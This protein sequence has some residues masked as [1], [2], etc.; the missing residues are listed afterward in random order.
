MAYVNAGRRSCTGRTPSEYRNPIRRL[1][2]TYHSPIT[3]VAINVWY[4]ITTDVHHTLQKEVNEVRISASG[5]RIG[6]V[7]IF[8]A[9]GALAFQSIPGTDAKTAMKQSSTGAPAYPVNGDGQTY[10]F[11]GDPASAETAP[12][13]I[14][15]GN[16]DGTA[17]YVLKTDVLGE[18]PKTSDDGSVPVYA[19]DG[20]TE[21]GSF[22]SGAMNR[23]F[24]IAPNYP[25]NENGQTYGS[26][27]DAISNETMPDLIRAAGVDGTVGYVRKEDLEEEQPKTPEE[28][29]ALQ[30]KRPPGGRDI[31][32]YDADGKT[33][34]GVFHAG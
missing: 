2:V 5:I 9:G 7:C 21:I 19:V 32:L 33:V 4:S 25:K 10:G 1:L 30:Q 31:P 20:K 11:P 22:S 8:V 14:L 26:A 18:Q 15:A 13:L 29:I 6:I 34:I 23:I 12:D 3:S 27:A 17:A 28:A 16:V 24:A